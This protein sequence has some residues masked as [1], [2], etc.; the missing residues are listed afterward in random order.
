MSATLSLTRGYG[1]FFWG[2]AKFA[3]SPYTSTFLGIASANGCREEDSLEHVAAAAVVCGI[4]T[5]VV[6]ILPII[7]AF[8]TT[9]SMIAA[10]LAALSMIATYPFAIAIDAC[11]GKSCEEEFELES[12]SVLAI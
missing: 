6:P 1:S 5:F 3:V 2:C 7:S 10:S 12:G 4:L 11:T 8:T 9:L